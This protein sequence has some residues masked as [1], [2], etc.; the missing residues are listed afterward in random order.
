MRWEMYAAAVDFTET[1][2]EATAM[3]QTR[4]NEHYV[5]MTMTDKRDIVGGKINRTW[6][7]GSGKCRILGKQEMCVQ[8][9]SAGSRW[10][11]CFIPL[12]F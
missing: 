5:G 8:N 2:Q 7:Q 1:S 12:S 11:S 10:E 6:Q 9:N 4:E 3:V